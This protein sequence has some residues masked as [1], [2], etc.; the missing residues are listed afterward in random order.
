MIDKHI[1]NA[2]KGNN[3][4]IS[5]RTTDQMEKMATMM[6]KV[7]AEMAKEMNPEYKSLKCPNCGSVGTLEEFNNGC[8]YCG[9][10]Y[11]LDYDNK[12]LGGKYYYDR[13][14]KG[15]GYKVRTLIVDFIVSFILSL[16]F[17]FI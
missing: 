17:I 12:D 9:T 5:D 4:D 3:I 10:H 13:T 7:A 1:D 15:H 8:P 11:N 14:L 2:S 16:L 6:G